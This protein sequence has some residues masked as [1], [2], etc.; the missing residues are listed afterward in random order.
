MVKGFTLPRS[1][2]GLAAIDPPPPWHY[3]GDAV[4][5]EYWADPNATAA[6]LP[7]GLSPDADEPLAVLPCS[8]SSRGATIS[9]VAASPPL[10]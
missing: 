9:T 5:V 2:L 6:F 7:E 10:P 8:T 1:P 3:S 4:G